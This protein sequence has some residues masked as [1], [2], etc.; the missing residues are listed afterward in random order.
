[1]NGIT[2]Q[3]LVRA[4]ATLH[5]NG[6]CED[7]GTAI[8]AA[9]AAHHSLTGKRSAAPPTDWLGRSYRDD[10]VDA[11]LAERGLTAATLDEAAVLER[12]AR[13][14]AEGEIVGW[15]QGRSEFGPRAL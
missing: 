13:A 9:L 4:G 10:E 1:L 15:F 14:I 5:M 2:N 11:A 3:A 7:N 12:A 6:S 8:G